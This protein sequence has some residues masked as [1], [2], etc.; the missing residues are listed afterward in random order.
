MLKGV[1]VKR[2]YFENNHIGA[3]CRKLCQT[4]TQLK[5]F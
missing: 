1:N 4:L 5:N 3:T 2:I